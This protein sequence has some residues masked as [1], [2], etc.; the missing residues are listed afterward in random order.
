MG[1]TV[2]RLKSGEEIIYPWDVVAEWK[3]VPNVVMIKA[4]KGE[5]IDI[6]N[7]NEVVFVICRAEKET[8]KD[9]EGPKN[10]VR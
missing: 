8:P 4:N 6:Y 10:E 7:A 5:K 2:V 3:N 9:E 1:E